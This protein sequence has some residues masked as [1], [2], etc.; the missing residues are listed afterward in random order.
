M[1]ILTVKGIIDIVDSN[2]V[3]A[4]VHIWATKPESITTGYSIP[5]VNDLPTIKSCLEDFKKNGGGLV[6]DCTPYGC[7]RDGNMLYYISDKTR[8]EIACVTGFYRREYYPPGS[9]IWDLDTESA[10]AFFIQEIKIGLKETLNK[11]KKIKAGIIKIPFTGLLTGVYKKLTD[12]AIRA[13]VETGFPVIVHTEQGHNV[14]LFSDYLE[15]MG[16]KPQKVVLCHIDKRR[17]IALHE[18]LASRGFYLEYD[19]FLR[20]KYQPEKYTYDLMIS[21][22]KSGFSNSL[23]IGSDIFGNSMWKKVMLRPGYGGFFKKM[24]QFLESKSK[25]PEIV[26]NILGGNAVRFLSLKG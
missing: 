19:T 3:D 18:K 17:D 9:E 23:M 16:V 8:L 21:M 22:I 14:E 26:M 24:E 11:A 13:A 12:A 25:D 1:K 7:G 20:E 15:E 6:I 4:H 5:E 2:I 10:E